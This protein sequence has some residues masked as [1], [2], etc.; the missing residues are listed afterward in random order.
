MHFRHKKSLLLQSQCSF[1]MIPGGSH[2][3]RMRAHSWL[4]PWRK[5]YAHLTPMKKSTLST[6]PA[7]RSAT[8]GSYKALP[9]YLL[10]WRQEARSPPCLKHTHSH[11]SREEE[12]EERLDWD[13]HPKCCFLEWL[14]SAKTQQKVTK[15][16][17]IKHNMKNAAFTCFNLWISKF[18]QAAGDSN[19]VSTVRILCLYNQQWLFS[20]TNTYLFK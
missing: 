2:E 15:Q 5:V 11:I 12:E 7:A 13:A 6:G 4:W 1:F 19:L 18:E 20:S 3:T 17:K 16:N 9:S 8:S 14:W 10:A